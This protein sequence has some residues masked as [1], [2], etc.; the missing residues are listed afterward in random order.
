MATA[1]QNA[2]VAN[3]DVAKAALAAAAGTVSQNIR[4]QH[5]H[6]AANSYQ[7]MIL[8]RQPCA[9]PRTVS[10]RALGRSSAAA[11]RKTCSGWKKALASLGTDAYAVMP[12][13]M[14]VEFLNGVSA[15]NVDI[16]EKFEKYIEDQQ[17][18][19]VLG[20]TLTSGS[21]NGAGSYAL[22]L[23]HNEVG[24]DILRSDAK[25]LASTLIRDLI[26]PLVDFN[27]G[28]E[29]PS[30]VVRFAA[31]EGEDL[32]ALAT[33]LSLTA[34]LGIAVPA[35]WARV[36]FGIPEPQDGEELLAATAVPTGA[37]IPKDGKPLPPLKPKQEKGLTS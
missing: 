26:R 34:P 12:N 29:F 28:T 11:R 5:L 37:A 8:R 16:F 4:D 25:Q 13:D 6:P 27:F 14:K 3:I 24:M 21:G 2:V 32:V 9:T 33:V 23:V 30:P 22:G 36:K 35:K 20:Q 18:R 7:Q 31:D 1:S 17:S 15:G 10:R 19:L